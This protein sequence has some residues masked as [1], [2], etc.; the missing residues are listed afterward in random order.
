MRKDKL[1]KSLE[2]IARSPYCDHSE[3]LRR[4]VARIKRQKQIIKE[5]KNANM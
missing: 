5:L 4:A 2:D 1:I 3:L